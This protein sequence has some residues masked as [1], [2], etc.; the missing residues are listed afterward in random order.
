MLSFSLNV[1]TDPWALKE[2]ILVIY[3]ISL[4]KSIESWAV[5]ISYTRGKIGNNLA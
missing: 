5:A 1:K 3:Y 4:Y 2:N